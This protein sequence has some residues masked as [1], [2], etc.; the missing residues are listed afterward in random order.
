MSKEKTKSPKEVATEIAGLSWQLAT[1]TTHTIECD[2]CCKKCTMYG[3]TADV[4]TDLYKDGWRHDGDSSMTRCR[5]CN[6]EE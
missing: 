3:D 2:E 1:E 6:D 5:N 4:A